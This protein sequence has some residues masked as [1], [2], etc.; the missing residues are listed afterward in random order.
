MRHVEP[1]QIFVSVGLFFCHPSRR[2]S[3]ECEHPI[4][5]SKC[6][7][8]K[9]LVSISGSKITAPM[10]S[11]KTTD[12]SMFPKLP[13]RSGSFLH[14]GW[15]HC[16]VFL[17]VSVLHSRLLL[18]VEHA[19]CFCDDDAL[20]VTAVVWSD[21]QPLSGLVDSQEKL[22]ICVIKVHSQVV[23][24]AHGKIRIKLEGTV[25]AD[26]HVQVLLGVVHD[27]RYFIYHDCKQLGW[28]ATSETDSSTDLLNFSSN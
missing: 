6:G 15:C 24:G 1:A 18:D 3:S 4:E 20:V 25:V 17:T 9:P 13:T 22:M 26:Q 5:A 10:S 11:V 21:Y 19:V 23:F 28:L 27:H 16:M 14:I 2:R 12:L 7:L 8:F